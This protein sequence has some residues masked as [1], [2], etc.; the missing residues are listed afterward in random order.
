[1]KSSPWVSRLCLGRS[2]V[3]SLG[4][5]DDVVFAGTVAVVETCRDFLMYWMIDD[6]VGMRLREGEAP[7]VMS[8]GLGAYRTGEVSG[9]E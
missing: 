7:L 2:M 5:M 4:V 3:A 1:M 8:S 9:S 6:G